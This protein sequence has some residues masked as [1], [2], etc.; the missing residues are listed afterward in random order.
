MFSPNV[1][2]A[3]SDHPVKDTTQPMRVNP[4]IGGRIVIEDNCWIGSN[5]TITKDVTIGKE[6]VIGANSV[7]THDIPE[8]SIAVGCPAKVI[9]ARQ[10]LLNLPRL[11]SWDS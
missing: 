2:V 4:A 3:A 6:S 11:K 10:V 8:Y 7:V 1:V 5:V 9:S